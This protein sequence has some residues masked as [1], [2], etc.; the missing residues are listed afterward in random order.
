M[1]AAMAPMKP[2]SLVAVALLRE[3]VVVAVRVAMLMVVLRDMEAPVPEAMG[4]LPV[5]AG[6]TG[7]ADMVPLVDC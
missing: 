1:P 2:A 4:A 6:V 7:T 5:P 3:L